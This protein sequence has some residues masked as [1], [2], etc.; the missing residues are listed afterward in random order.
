MNAQSIGRGAARPIARRFAWLLSLLWFA[1]LSAAADMNLGT[2]FTDLWWNSPAKSEDG[3]GMTVDHQDQVMFV[4]LYVYRADTSSY[5]AVATLNHVDGSRYTFTGD[6]YDAHGPWFGGP[7]GATPYVPRKVGTATFTATEPLHATLS[8]TVEG[9]PVN[10][11]LERQTLRFVNFSGSY[12]GAISFVTSNCA[13]PADNNDVTADSGDMTIT[14][15]G[16]GMSIA[17]TGREAACTFAGTYGQSGALGTTPTTLSCGTPTGPIAGTFNLANMQW[18][19]AG[20]TATVS[21]RLQNCDIN[22]AIV[23]ALRSR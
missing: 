1:S 13:N 7:Y 4:T 18:T 8:Y 5:W 20:M 10:K 19:I 16:S 22:G 15:S 2:M 6:L 9:T 23:G 21:G 11:P 3:W 14:H 17:Y 12:F